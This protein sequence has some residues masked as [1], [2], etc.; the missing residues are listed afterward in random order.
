MIRAV[1]W[2]REVVFYEVWVRSFHDANG[3]GVGDLAGLLARLDY[4]Q[5]LGVGAIWLSPVF[6]SPWADAGYDVTD[7]CDI[8][9]QLGTLAEFDQLVREA[10]RR[11]IRVVL[12][13]PVNHTSDRHPWFHDARS[14]KDAAHR[15]WYVWVDPKQDGALP[16]NWLSVFGG[17]AWTL[18]D[19]TGQYYFH[20]FLPEQ[21]D[22]NWRN[23]AV[24][25]A[26]HE[27]MRFWLARGVDGF[28]VDAIDMLLEHPERPDNP[29]DPRF[30]PD[31][32]PDAAVFQVH[33]R[34]QPGLH[35]LIAALR[36]LCDEF[37]DRVLIGEAY[38]SLENLASYYGT[39]TE[40]ELHLPLNPELLLKE[41]WSPDDV[42]R[43]VARYVDV[44][45]SRGWPN[46][47]WTNHDFRRLASRAGPDQLHVAAM[48]LLTLRGTPFVYYG[49]E[50]GMHDVEIPPERVEDPQ[51][52]AQPR[53]NRDLARTPMQW[54]DERH[55]GFTRGMPHAPVA[56]DFATVN[57]AAQKRDPRSL[58]ALYRRLI[59]LRN[60]EPA[61]HAGRQTDLACQDG[62]LSFRRELPGRRIV[63]V[64]NMSNEE[65]VC[66]LTRHGENGRIL[67]STCLDIQHEYCGRQV[68]L[69]D[70]EGLV[71]ALE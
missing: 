23:P 50:I 37:G 58:L 27:A 14:R 30:D 64:L 63:I 22:L 44:V 20:A 33:N 1:P 29:P 10:H 69:R 51:G 55:A 45:S 36:R 39:S 19:T 9:P 31:G 16:N 5:W 48:L 25:A 38:T 34:S 43:A 15:D 11:A 52:R 59:A 21:P 12:D 56:D 65:R 26:I 53:R 35:R 2:W 17:S 71:L 3:D 13:W 28:R 68:R 46:W 47:A 6:P 70:H 7:F 57:V 24:R 49:E 32:P 66:D 40:P 61:L 18:D 42:V 41:H 60:N 62:L 4:L 54:S 67:L 8:H